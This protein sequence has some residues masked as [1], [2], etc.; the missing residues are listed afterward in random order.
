MLIKITVW[1]RS[2][3]SDIIH[4]STNCSVIC[5][6]PTS[7]PLPSSQ[8]LLPTL[9]GKQSWNDKMPCRVCAFIETT[10]L[11][12]WPQRSSEF[13]L[14][15]YWKE[16]SKMVGHPFAAGPPPSIPYW[17]APKLSKDDLKKVV[18][19]CGFDALLN[20]VFSIYSTVVCSSSI[21]TITVQTMTQ[22][23][24]ESQV[25]DALT[26]DVIRL[27]PCWCDQAVP[28]SELLWIMYWI[29]QRQETSFA[30]FIWV[31]FHSR[32]WLCIL[33]DTKPTPS[34]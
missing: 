5:P 2:W 12:C 16:S 8:D 33:E 27:L 28:S 19:S 14:Q 10:C 4:A 32:G 30:S 7:F 31:H 11:G 18:H 21:V 29:C 1:D 26:P 6:L 20:A 13:T 34:D 17:W 25:R 22:D 23:R 24:S 15:H 9:G 3:A